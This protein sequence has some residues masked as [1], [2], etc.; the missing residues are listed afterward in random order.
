MT[1]NTYNQYY[2]NIDSLIIIIHSYVTL[3]GQ[4]A[5]PAFKIMHGSKQKLLGIQRRSDNYY[6]CTSSVDNVSRLKTKVSRIIK[7]V[8][9][10]QV[11]IASLKL[12]MNTVTDTH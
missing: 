9:Y 8:I 2:N 6:Y 3:S 12:K 7:V 1:C 4:S 5:V 11:N 10:M